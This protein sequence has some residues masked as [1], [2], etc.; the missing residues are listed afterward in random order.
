MQHLACIMDGNRRYALQHGWQPWI[1]HEKGVEAVR[2]ALDFCLQQGISYLS[3]YTLS[4]ENLKRSQ[5]EK[6]FLFTLIANSAKKH[7]NE[8]L[9]K[10]IKIRFVGDRTL[11]PAHLMPTCDEVEH[12]T[13]H[14]TNLQVNFLF[15]YGGKQEIVHAVKEIARK[16]K[17]GQLDEH[18]VSED[19][20]AQH[21]W[22]HDTPVP[23]LIIRT[24]GQM[25]TS[26]FLLYQSAYSEYYFTDKYWPS[27]T[28]DDL[29]QACKQFIGRKR[30]YGV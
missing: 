16:V 28:A 21:L 6:D 20:I 9:E 14:C 5:A 13:A 23:D 3:L 24:G 4:I 29:A 27:I 1:G 15:C 12:K 25:R 17:A 7:L 30:N 2:V 10:G 22:T 8:A 18:D 19:L 26:N 11:F